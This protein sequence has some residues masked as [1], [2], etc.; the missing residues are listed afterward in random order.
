MPAHRARFAL[1]GAALA[2]GSAPALGDTF[3]AQAHWLTGTTHVHGLELDVAPGTDE[4]SLLAGSRPRLWGYGSLQGG[5]LRL[6]LLL[7]STR[8]GIGTSLFQIDGVSLRTNALPAGTD[9]RA[10]TIWGSSFELFIGRELGQGPVYPYLDGRLT[11][12]MVQAQVET[13]A[14]P[15][16]HV[17]TTLYDAMHFGVGPRLGVLVPIGHSTMLDI[18]LSQRLFGGFEETVIGIGI[19]YWENDRTDAFSE[20]LRGHSWRGQI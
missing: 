2:L 20:E 8:L 3:G 4:P 12:S 9:A 19:G 10:G 7:D 18:T 16:G 17:G 1:L 11:F 6:D 13:Y 15:Y 14:E 5:S